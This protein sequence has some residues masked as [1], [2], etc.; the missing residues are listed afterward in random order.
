[1]RLKA[2][3]GGPGGGGMIGMKIYAP[4]SL[5]KKYDEN[6]RCVNCWRMECMNEHLREPLKAYYNYN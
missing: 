5:T 4:E 6:K 2:K 3:G 1:M